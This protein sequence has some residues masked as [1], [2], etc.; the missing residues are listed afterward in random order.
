MAT[1]MNSPY[2]TVT[3]ALSDDGLWKTPVKEPEVIYRPVPYNDPADPSPRAPIWRVRFD[4]VYDPSRCFGLEINGEAALGRDIESPEI[5]NLGAYD[6]K[7]LGVSRRHALLRPTETGLYLLDLGSTNGTW[8]NGRSI[9][10]NM[11]YRLTHGDLIRLGQLEFMVRIVKR[12]SEHTAMLSLKADR[13]A[14]LVPV[15]RAITSQLD[16]D[17]VLNQA[18][19]II[20][21]M[22]SVDEA[23]VWLVD[24]QTGELFLEASR[25]I[26]DEHIKRMRLPVSDTLPGKAIEAGQLLHVNNVSGEEKVK[27]KTGYLVDS[28]I[29][30]PLILG[31]V[32][33][34]VLSAA[35]RRPGSLFSSDD[36]K[37]L[38]AIADLTAVAVQN[39]RLYR[40]ATNAL[41][42]QTKMVTALNYGL[43]YDLRNKANSVI[44]YADLLSMD[45]TLNEESTEI[46]QKIVA[47]GNQMVQLMGGLLEV[48]TLN[49][50]GML[51]YTACNL[52]LTVRRAVRDIEAAAREKAVRLDFTWA[53]EVYLIRGDS[54]RLYHSARAAGQRTQVLAPWD[55]CPG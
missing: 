43:S 24:E 13:F 51:P 28:V 36:E 33:F 30:V 9:G 17:E 7:A 11:P 21:S 26:Q 1:E 15:A 14:A 16:F 32:T 39:S 2:E 46:A 22:T 54:T 5:V 12:P 4:L 50:V 52:V 41:S 6:A 45:K 53:G 3:R 40:A 25:G 31:G 10:V 23:S 48:S 47:A 27:V 35:H 49:E 44:G 37:L 20:I 8:Q 18:L 38:T 29:Y 19:D 55:I 42:R 34:G